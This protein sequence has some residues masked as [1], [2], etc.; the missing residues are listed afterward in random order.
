MS[1]FSI[2]KK[3]LSFNEAASFYFKMKTGNWNN[4]KLKKLKHPF[5]IRDNPYDFATLEE[6]V[7]KEEY[8]IELSFEPRTIIDGGANIGLTSI[9]FANKYPDAQIVSVEPEAG[10]FQML[11][12]NT[13]QY[14][15]ISLLNAGIWNRNTNLTIVD[16]GKG[17]NSFTVE[18]LSVP[19]KNSIE[20]I[21]IVDIL[22]ER[23]WKTIDILKLD[24]EGSEKNVFEKNY[25]SWLPSVKVLVIELHDRIIDGCSETVFEALANYDF[26]R[27]V[28]GENYIFINKD[29]Q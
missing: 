1:R 6:V 11:R 26:S 21:S 12:K 14:P 3:H 7:L 25:E 24:I 15:N 29:L 8:D 28:K 9:F 23:K 4:F 2:L 18:E 20:A 17:H 5:S 22:H 10:N 27:E 13:K 19:T 16:T